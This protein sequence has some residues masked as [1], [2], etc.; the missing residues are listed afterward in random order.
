VK[1][2]HLCDG[3]QRG[4][5]GGRQLLGQAPALL[6]SWRQGERAD[7]SRPSPGR[8]AGQTQGRADGGIAER[9]LQLAVV[10]GSL[11]GGIAQ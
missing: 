1:G 2:V 4:G 9:R 6:G 5:H 8:V 3:G 11:N 7:G 10:E